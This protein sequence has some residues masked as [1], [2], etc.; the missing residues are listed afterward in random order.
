L[1]SQG[2][3]VGLVDDLLQKLIFFVYFSPFDISISGDMPAT[4]FLIVLTYS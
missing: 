3:S 4:Y 1:Q 2:S